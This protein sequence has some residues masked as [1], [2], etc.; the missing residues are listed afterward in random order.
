L[1]DF[2]EA[3]I[4][5]KERSAALLHLHLLFSFIVRK[6]EMPQDAK[7]KGPSPPDEGEEQKIVPS[8]EGTGIRDAM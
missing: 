6:V 5:Q 8:E 1:A 4:T 2:D 3:L 7:G